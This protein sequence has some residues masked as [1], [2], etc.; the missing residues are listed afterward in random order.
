MQAS[1]SV[2]GPSRRSLDLEDYLDILRRHAAWILGPAFAGLVVAVV[3]AFLWSDTYVS[4]ATIRVV[5]PQVPSNLVQTNVVS[6]M[7]TRINSM[8]QTISS[9]SQLTNLINVYNLYPR[10]RQRK[11][12]LDVVEQMRRSVRLGNVMSVGGDGRGIGAF[13]ISF[14]YENRVLAQKVT[15]DLVS[16]FMSENTRERT[17]Q[18]VL[19]T[20][21]LKDQLESAK[22]ELDEVDSKLSTYRQSYQG[23]LPEQAGQNQMQLNNLEQRVGN[24]N[25]AL[26]RI[27]Q[28]KLILESD[29]RSLKSQRASLIPAPESMVQRRRNAAIDAQDREIL[30]L[31][32]RLANLQERYKD[33]WPEVRNTVTQLGVARKVRDKLLA[34]E[35]NQ[36]ANEVAAAESGT[37]QSD[38]VVE[39]EQRVLDASI[40]RIE[41]LRKAKDMEL[42]GYSKELENVNAKIRGM[43]ER[44]SASPASEQQYV[45]LLREQGLVKAKYEDYNRKRSQSA[46]SEE[47]ERRQ[48]GETLELLDPASLPQT[49]TQP[50][51]PMIMAAGFGAGLALGIAL[52]GA[53]EARD[54]TLKNLK[55]VRAYTQLNV[56]GSIPLL[57]NDLV[58]RRRR[59]LAWL[60]WSTACLVGILIMTGSVFY[61]YATKV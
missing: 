18:S 43:Q 15:A 48:Q 53:R 6:D 7:S 30:H 37:K 47:L 11:P 26:A 24:I 38:P 14:K 33:T 54:N 3:V 59:R 58:V 35:Q 13:Q 20:Q 17:T 55:D 23:R 16:R 52:A 8:Y 34:R 31:E 28:D 5:P 42:A 51:R 25:G 1:D 29:L 44:I 45:E 27:S 49:P 22:K 40:E 12:M 50:K 9:T 60:A 41:T 46:V 2:N 61:Y 32:I 57:E 39:R 19:T 4:A 21:F 56:L 10:D 36:Q